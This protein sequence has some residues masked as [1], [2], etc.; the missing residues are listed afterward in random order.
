M[1]RIALPT[2]LVCAGLVLFVLGRPTLWPQGQQPRPYVPPPG[3]SGAPAL[4]GSP[5]DEIVEN[6]RQVWAALK[7]H[8]GSTFNSLLADDAMIVTGGQRYTKPEYL[9]TLNQI[10]I[11]DYSLEDIQ[12]MMTGPDSAIINYQVSGRFGRWDR[13]APPQMF[14]VASV[15]VRRNGRWL[16]VFNMD[17]PSHFAGSN[18]PP[19]P[20]PEPAAPSSPRAL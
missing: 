20:G 17:S 19:R 10:D 14:Q 6:E 16:T 5:A 13:A 4:P 18:A 7:N 12:V 9:A 3:S 15:W 11:T 8:D 2:L 1:K